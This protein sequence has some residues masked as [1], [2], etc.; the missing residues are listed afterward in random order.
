ASEQALAVARANADALRLEVEWRLA[1]ALAPGFALPAGA[2][3]VV[4]N[5]PY[6]PVEEAGTLSPRVRAREPHMALFAP[7]GDPLAFYRAIGRAAL[8]ALAE[9]G[10]LWF[11][12]HH[13]FAPRAAGLLTAMGYGEA[14]LLRDMSGNPR[15]IRALRRPRPHHP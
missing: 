11:E 8:P 5:P 4:S 14:L 9:A 6:I 12:A 13:R 7:A 10:E 15:F 3:L 2:D 1:D